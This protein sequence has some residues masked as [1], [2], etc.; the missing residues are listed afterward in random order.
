MRL[1]NLLPTKISG[2]IS[3]CAKWAFYGLAI[4]SISVLWAGCGDE[5]IL[6]PRPRAYPRVEFP[7]K[8]YQTF[9]PDYCNFTFQYPTYTEV[10]Q[11]TSFFDGKP[12]HPCWFDIFYPQFDARLHFTYAPV[13]SAEELDKLRTEAFKM[14]DW[15]NK[16]AN[17]IQEIRISKADHNVDG[18][19]FDITGPAASPFQFYL[20]DNREHF[21]RASL[22]FNTHIN[23]D[24]LAPMYDFVKM[25]ITE[26]IDTFEWE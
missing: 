16:K 5:D 2:H 17:Y 21:V 20:T 15:Q 7:E 6:T 8:T 26:L 3:A 9:D 12:T 25:D 22:Y 1:N 14:A 18:I 10:I 19:G 4:T 11:D 24:S 23:P 13:S